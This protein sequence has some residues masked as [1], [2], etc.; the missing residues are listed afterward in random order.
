MWLIFFDKF[1]KSSR[2]PWPAPAVADDAKG[3]EFIVVDRNRGFPSCQRHGYCGWLTL[4]FDIFG[5]DFSGDSGSAVIHFVLVVG[6][7]GV[8]VNFVVGEVVAV[9]IAIN[10]E[11]VVVCIFGFFVVVV[12][13]VTAVVVCACWLDLVPPPRSPPPLG[14]PKH[15][16]FHPR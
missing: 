6:C 4:Y 2:A 7:A 11:Y 3:L 15:P 10:D 8:V 14:Q 5:G 13:L 16:P 12:V 1:R 9:G